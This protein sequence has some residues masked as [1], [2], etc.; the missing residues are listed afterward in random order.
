MD[1]LIWIE[2]IIELLRKLLNNENIEKQD[3]N[4]YLREVNGVLLM[5]EIVESFEFSEDVLFNKVNFDKC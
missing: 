4:V 1:G 2:K 3:E 5:L